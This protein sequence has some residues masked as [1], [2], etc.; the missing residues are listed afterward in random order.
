[1][2]FKKSTVIPVILKWCLCQQNYQ[3]I[4][5]KQNVVFYFLNFDGHKW[6][7]FFNQ[8]SRAESLCKHFGFICIN[9][10]LNMI[11]LKSFQDIHLINNIASEKM[12]VME[13]DITSPS[14]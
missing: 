9:L 7:S 4:E 1:M 14:H 2:I 3:N 12:T 11:T 10:F 8:L 13:W 6:I 5:Y